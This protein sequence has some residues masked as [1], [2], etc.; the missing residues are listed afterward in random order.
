MLESRRLSMFFVAAVCLL[1]STLVKAFCPQAPPSTHSSF[2][3]HMA[4]RRGRPKGPLRTMEEKPTMNNE[5]SYTELR[6]VTP[7]PKGKDEAL[8]IMSK[9]EALIKAKDMGGLDLILINENSDPPVC[10]IV[11]YSK[12]RYAK[13][14]KAKEVKKNSKASEAK[15]V[16][17]SYKIDVHDYS[18]RLKNAGKFLKQGNRVKCTV[19]FRGR[20]VQ[21][22]NLGFDL[23]DKMAVDLEDVCLKEGKPKREGRNLSCILSPR[24]EV[25]KAINDQKR[26]EERE[27]KKKREESL[28]EKQEAEMVGAGAGAAAVSSYINGEASEEDDDILDKIRVEDDD[29]DEDGDLSSSLDDLLG[30]DDLTDDLFG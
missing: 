18:V 1:L 3:L 26:K 4:Q 12:W 14:K 11:D 29:D 5:I 20:E 22:D 27:K 7:N 6:V 28:K 2:T 13:E 10:K 9:Q 25:L 24:P 19:M 8:G 16:K 17:M 23:L 21:H 30:G 15:E